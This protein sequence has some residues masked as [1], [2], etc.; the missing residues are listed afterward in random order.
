MLRLDSANACAGQWTGAGRRQT[1]RRL[2]LHQRRACV[3]TQIARQRER[4]VA[5]VDEK[6][7]Q[8]GNRGAGG[9]EAERAG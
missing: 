4:A 8:T 3:R 5:I 1:L 7:L 6:L 2:K 9:A